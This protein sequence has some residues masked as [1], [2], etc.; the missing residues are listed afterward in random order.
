MW[1]EE[2]ITNEAIKKPSSE[3]DNSEEGIKAML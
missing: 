2:N 1:T 3:F